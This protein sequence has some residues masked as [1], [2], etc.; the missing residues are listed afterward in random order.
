MAEIGRKGGQI[1]AKRLLQKMSPEERKPL[2]QRTA[3][4]R[5]GKRHELERKA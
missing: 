3:K 5:W 1:G 4:V 2:A